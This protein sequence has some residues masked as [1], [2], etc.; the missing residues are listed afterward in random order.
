M[1]G[2]LRGRVELAL[3]GRGHGTRVEILYIFLPSQIMPFGAIRRKAWH[4]GRTVPSMPFLILHHFGHATSDISFSSSGALPELIA[5]FECS[6]GKVK[7]IGCVLA[8]IRA[9]WVMQRRFEMAV[10]SEDPQPPTPHPP[11]SHV[12]QGTPRPG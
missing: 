2:H 9:G 4:E 12:L 7:G 8:S 5:K 10:A 3:T 1:A 6:N 11:P